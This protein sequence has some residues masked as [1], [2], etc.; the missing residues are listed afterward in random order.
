MPRRHTISELSWIHR[1][2][3]ISHHRDVGPNLWCELGHDV[4][5]SPSVPATFPSLPQISS[6]FWVHWV[7]W[8]S[9]HHAPSLRSHRQ[10][11][12]S[13]NWGPSIIWPQIT[14][15][16]LQPPGGSLCPVKITQG[17]LVPVFSHAT[18]EHEKNRNTSLELLWVIYRFS[19]PSKTWN[20]EIIWRHSQ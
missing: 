1:M 18:L 9:H 8:V 3:W 14:L 2:F 6:C 13:P 11:W 4:R 10:S 20:S 16:N 12:S 15:V 7:F 17:R 19:C 5:P